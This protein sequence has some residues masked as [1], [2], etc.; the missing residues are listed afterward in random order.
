MD[1]MMLDLSFSQNLPM[2][3]CYYQHQSLEKLYE[4]EERIIRDL[5]TLGYDASRPAER[6]R[7]ELQTDSQNE[8]VDLD[9]DD[10]PDDD[11]DFI[12]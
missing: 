8:A 2:E 9:D 6:E 3:F 5:G 12:G 4:H 7:E 11:I 10:D 1:Q